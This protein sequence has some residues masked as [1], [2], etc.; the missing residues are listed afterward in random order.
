MYTL[1]LGSARAAVHSVADWPS[2]KAFLCI[3]ERIVWLILHFCNAVTLLRATVNG[4]DTRRGRALARPGA[5]PLL[6]GFASISGKSPSSEN[7]GGPSP[8]ECD[9][10]LCASSASGDRRAWPF[11]PHDASRSPHFAPACC[12]LTSYASAN[13][14]VSTLNLSERGAGA[15]RLPGSGRRRRH[16][17]ESHH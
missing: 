3:Y 1:G 16:A 2:G 6:A 9:P 15:A 14:L 4:P 7:T 8:S 13:T 10:A 5:S 11:P 12:R 17:I